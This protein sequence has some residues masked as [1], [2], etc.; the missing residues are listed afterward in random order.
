MRVQSVLSLSGSPDAAGALRA[1]DGKTVTTIVTL[2]GSQNTETFGEA[3]R[4][5]RDQAKAE[6]ADI[7]LTVAITGPAGIVSDAV[8]V[9][10]TFDFRVTM[11]TV[12]LVLVLLLVIYR[13]PALALLPLVGVG[14]TLLVAQSVAALLAENFGLSLNGQVTALMSVLMFGAGTDFT[15]FIVARYREELR[16]QPESL[17]GHGGLAAADRAGDRFERGDHDCGHAGAVAGQLRLIPGDGAGAG[18]GDLP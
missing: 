7:G 16:R 1:P 12:L 17:A 5:V 14:W 13:S 4:W 6:V 2:A 11:V 15:L 18:D 8:E 3:V 10:G 9:F